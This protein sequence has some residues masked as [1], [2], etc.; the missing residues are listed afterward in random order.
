M[1]SLKLGIVV[2]LALAACSPE[3]PA[4]KAD[5][6]KLAPGNA[7]AG[8]PIAEKE[9]K[10]CHGLDG[11]GAAPG[12]PHLAAQSERYLVS[13]LKEYKDNNRTHAALRA[14]AEGLTDADTR[15][16]AAYYAGLPPVQLAAQ[17]QPKQLTPCAP[18]HPPHTAVSGSP[19]AASP[20]GAAA[21]CTGFCEAK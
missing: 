4:G 9:C 18:W 17:T 12:I 19:A 6:A 14:I 10:G 11:K 21:R 13:A 16:V 15:N 7:A 2:S 3:Q 5:A 8:K 20:K 1:K